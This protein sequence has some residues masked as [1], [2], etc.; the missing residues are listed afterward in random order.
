VNFN[1]RDTS[2]SS[3]LSFL[4]EREPITCCRDT[5]MMTSNHKHEKIDYFKSAQPDRPHEL[6]KHILVQLKSSYNQL[7]EEPLPE[8]IKKLLTELSE[9]E[10]NS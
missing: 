8:N 3:E 6:A 4:S 7:L 1:R 5:A 9:R 2:N 10:N